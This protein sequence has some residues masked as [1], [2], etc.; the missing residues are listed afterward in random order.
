MSNATTCAP[1]MEKHDNAVIQNGFVVDTSP[2][3]VTV[4]V[5]RQTVSAT[6]AFSCL[7]EPEPGDTVA[8]CR[9]GFGNVYILGILHRGTP[10][11]ATVAF[12][13]GAT[14]K[15]KNADINLISDTFTCAGG[16]VNFFSKKEVHKS[17]DLYMDFDNAAMQGKQFQASIKTIRIVSNFI[18]T[19]ARQVIDKFKGY[20]RHTE[21]NDQVQAGQMTRRTDGLYS[22]DSRNTVMISKKE[23]KIDGEK[24]Y[25]A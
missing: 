20:V 6:K 11:E 16:S 12:P 8:C 3:A 14:L 24:I 10:K 4:T 2:Q 1:F 25:M 15:A 5:S 18:N 19:F 22:M 13:Y 23:T 9:D 17:N 7:V 21:D